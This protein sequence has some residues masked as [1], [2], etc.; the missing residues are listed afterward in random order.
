MKFEIKNRFRGTVQFTAEIDCKD[1]AST[2]V[3]IGLAVKW[4]FK[5]GAYL[6]GADL[7]GA[8][9]RGADLGGADL[10]GADLRG[11]DL[12]GADL[13]GADLGGQWIIQGGTR[14]DG[15]LFMLTNL[16]GEGVRVKAGCRNF[17]IS[18]AEAH[19]MRTRG[20]TALGKET[21]MIINAMGEIACLRGL[22]FDVIEKAA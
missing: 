9:L 1:D 13:G 21:F 17:S 4:A 11:A 15:Y 20:G 12:R 19:W 3:K 10:R 7:R 16:A 22:S 14:S 18:D 2:F 5:S 6:R 8:D